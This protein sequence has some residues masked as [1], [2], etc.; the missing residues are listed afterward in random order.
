MALS[1]RGMAIL[2][3]SM[4]AVMLLSGG[5]CA[6]QT[7]WIVGGIPNSW[8]W[9]D[10]PTFFQ[11]WADSVHP[12]VGDELEF[13]WGPASV[14]LVPSGPAPAPAPAPAGAAQSFDVQESAGDAADFEMGEP[15]PQQPAGL[16][17]SIW[18][19]PDEA[20]L[21]ACDF[22]ANGALQRFPPTSDTSTV[23][24]I[25]LPAPGK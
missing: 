17:H 12:K 22:T 2:F 1:W 3:V 23:H 21:D 16:P 11:D 19:L 8:T 20:S 10:V 25:P 5:G 6:G 13:Q 7:V 4:S 15:I 24:R 14:P 18:A 9:P